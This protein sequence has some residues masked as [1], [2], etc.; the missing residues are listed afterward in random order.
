[1]PLYWRSARKRAT[2]GGVAFFVGFLLERGAEISAEIW[3]R[4]R[5][6]A[7]DGVFCSVFV[8]FYGGGNYKS[9]KKDKKSL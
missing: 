3:T 5:E 2:R 4:K 7:R 9:D 6:Q 8:R 1:M